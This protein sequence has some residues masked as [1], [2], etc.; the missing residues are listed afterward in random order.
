MEIKFVYLLRT[1]IRMGEIYEGCENFTVLSLRI[2][3]LRI[4]RK[5]TISDL[6]NRKTKKL[7]LGGFWVRKLTAN[8]AT[9]YSR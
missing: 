8:S 1:N 7:N 2:L 9:N 4:L 5:F 3:E 6:L